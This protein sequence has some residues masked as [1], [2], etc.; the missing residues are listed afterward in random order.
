MK[1]MASRAAP[2]VVGAGEHHTP[3]RHI[4]FAR[5][6][7]DR[8]CFSVIPLEFPDLVTPLEWELIPA[9]ERRHRVHGHS[10]RKY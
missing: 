5:L 4:E 10:C 7:L 3:G 2:A 6:G 9:A 1:G 8:N